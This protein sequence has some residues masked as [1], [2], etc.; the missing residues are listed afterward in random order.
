MRNSLRGAHHPGLFLML[1]HMSHHAFDLSPGANGRL[2]PKQQA[3]PNS[4]SSQHVVLQGTL[5]SQTCTLTP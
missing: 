3:M 1:L 4:N 2:Q 5:Q